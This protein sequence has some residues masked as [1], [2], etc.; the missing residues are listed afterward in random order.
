VTAYFCEYSESCREPVRWRVHIR[1]RDGNDFMYCCHGHYL[2]TIADATSKNS[3]F[4][5]VGAVRVTGEG[6]YDPA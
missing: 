4:K 1:Y 3:T 2:Q 5:V 6:I